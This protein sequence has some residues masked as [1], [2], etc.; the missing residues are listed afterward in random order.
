M[1]KF[2]I[3]FSLT[4][5]KKKQWEQCLPADDVLLE[6]GLDVARG[7]AVLRHGDQRLEVL[8]L[9]VLVVL[10][11]ILPKGTTTCQ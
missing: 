6:H 4:S 8:R 2:V 5:S 9:Q 11:V 1:C 3:I 7:D 10:E